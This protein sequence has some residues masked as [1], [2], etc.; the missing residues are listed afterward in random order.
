[1]IQKPTD[2]NSEI[3][4]HKYIMKAPAEDAVLSLVETQK[5]TQQLYSNLS[6]EQANYKYAPEKWT[7]KQ[8][9]QHISDCERILAYRLLRL[10]RKDNTTLPGFDENSYAEN[11]PVQHLSTEEVLEEFNVVRASIIILVKRVASGNLDFTCIASKQ[12][13]SPRLLTWMI[14]GHN[15]HHLNILKERYHL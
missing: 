5:L 12:N 6:A 14:S 7:V 2:L 1:M 10:N 13:V 4:F 15:Q 3:Y 8:V 11:A 9:L